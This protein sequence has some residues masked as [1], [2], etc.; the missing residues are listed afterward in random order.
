M[1]NSGGGVKTGMVCLGLPCVSIYPNTGI[2]WECRGRVVFAGKCRIGGNSF[3]A[4]G[5]KGSVTFGDGFCA[6]ASLKLVSYHKIFFSENVRIGWNCLFCDTDMH[7]MTKENGGHTRGYAP[8]VIGKYNW[9]GNSCIVMKRTATPDY[10]TI[11]A[12]SRVNRSYMDIPERSILSNAAP[13]EVVRTG[14]WR[15]PYDDTI[16]YE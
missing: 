15:N 2:S 14:L 10:T 7:A 1:W 5:E 11:S 3:L 4:V 6:S 13:L 12:G 8:I 9:I 16:K